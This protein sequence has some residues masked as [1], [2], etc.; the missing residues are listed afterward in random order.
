MSNGPK[1][2]VQRAQTAAAQN[3]KVLAVEGKS[4]LAVYR[5]WLEKRLGSTWANKIQLEN[6]ES[7]P[8]LL[9]G[10]QW[11][12]A[13]NDPAKDV[14]FGLADRDEWEPG[15][16]ATLKAELPTLL[17]NETRHSLESYFCVR[18]ELVAILQARDAHTGNAVFTP[19]LQAL[20]LL[21][22]SARADYVPHW[23]LGCTIQRANERI[24][25]D[26]QYPV[27]FR[28]TCPLP[29]DAD[30]QA[31]L[32]AWAA[33]LQ[34]AT[35]FTTF[36]ALRAASLARPHAEQFRSCVEPKL[37]FGR[38]VVAGTQGLNAIQ[39]KPVEDWLVELARWSPAMPLDLEAV[40]TP[41]L[42]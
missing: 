5:E 26:Q 15:D 36:N 37:F 33:I 22:D 32:Q 31:K 25:N 30:I 42:T 34:P 13:T 11:L 27:F 9:A 38:I 2:W 35:L 1:A 10:L 8:P 7:R 18:D 39:Q 19:H 16:V 3:K 17:V 21:L 20:R 24:R 28:D 41:V 6:A 29:A 40:L 12:R 14:I 4:D 23:A